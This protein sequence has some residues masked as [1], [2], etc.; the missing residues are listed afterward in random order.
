[1]VALLPSSFQSE[2]D[3]GYDGRLKSKSFKVGILFF[4]SAAC[5]PYLLYSSLPNFFLLPFK[6]SIRAF[7]VRSVQSQP[8][9]KKNDNDSTASHLRIVPCVLI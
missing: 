7:A 4:D 1:M 5:T 6:V 2:V 9:S 3:R 8:E